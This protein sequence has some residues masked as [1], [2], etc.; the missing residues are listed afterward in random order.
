MLDFR[1]FCSSAFAFL[2][3]FHEIG[4]VIVRFTVT[5]YVSDV[6]VERE[7]ILF[8]ILFGLVHL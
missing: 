3:G 8:G 1:D 7:I 2:A 5:G 6:F 4:F